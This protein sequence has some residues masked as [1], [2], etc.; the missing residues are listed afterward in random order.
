MQLNGLIIYMLFIPILAA[1]LELADTAPLVRDRLLREG[2]AAY[3]EP[4]FLPLSE[5]G[6]WI[7]RRSLAA[8][9]SLSDRHS[10]EGFPSDLPATSLD[11]GCLLEV[12]NP[13]LLLHRQFRQPTNQ[14][15]S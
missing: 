4:S 9:L 13:M 15:G 2:R 12:D 5:A 3:I 10:H 6:P 7:T 14:P 8:W 1:Y 11:L